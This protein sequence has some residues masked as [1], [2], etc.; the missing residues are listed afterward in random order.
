MYTKK[1]HD[2]RVP[3]YTSVFSI[4]RACSVYLYIHLYSPRPCCGTRKSTTNS[5]CHSRRG[6]QRST[7][8]LVFV[9]FFSHFFFYSTFVVLVFAQLRARRIRRHTSPRISPAVH[10]ILIYTYI[11]TIILSDY[12]SDRYII[13][14]YIYMY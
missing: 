5:R 3:Y 10:C 13:C 8:C 11:S 7:H 9:F 1:F 6:Q 12:R 4:L 2:S 14:I